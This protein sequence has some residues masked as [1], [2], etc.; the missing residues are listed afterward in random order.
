MWLLAPTSIHN[1]A[2]PQSCP[3]AHTFTESLR[4][5]WRLGSLRLIPYITY[6]LLARMAL[7]MDTLH[8]MKSSWKTGLERAACVLASRLHPSVALSVRHMQATHLS[9][10]S[11]GK[12]QL[13]MP[14]PP[15]GSAKS[16][17]GNE[18]FVWL[19][20][21]AAA[22]SDSSMVAESE[23]RGDSRKS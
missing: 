2:V 12:Q 6:A 9:W 22:K 1:E 11:W 8:A 18:S 19:N 21:R 4:V 20:C 16:Q 15:P 17:T 7:A 10:N 14:Q 13:G 3:A 5:P 23:E